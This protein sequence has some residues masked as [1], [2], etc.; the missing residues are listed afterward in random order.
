MT[1]TN[2]ILE[3]YLDRATENGKTFFSY[4]LSQVTSEPI[5]DGMIIPTDDSKK[6]ILFYDPLLQSWLVQEVGAKSYTMLSFMQ[7]HFDYLYEEAIAFVYTLVLRERSSC[8][9]S[10]PNAFDANEHYYFDAIDLDVIE[11]SNQGSLVSAQVLG[12]EVA[13]FADLERMLEGFEEQ[14]QEDS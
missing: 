13:D 4:V 8:P 2:P 12:N 7:A 11:K 10:L 5:F 3:I 1:P 14:T 6:M 9:S